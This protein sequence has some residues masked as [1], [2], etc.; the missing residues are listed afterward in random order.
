MRRVS[1]SMTFFYKRIFPVLWFGI[2]GV[3]FIVALKDPI[4][5]LPFALGVLALMAFGYFFMRRFIFD[6][7]DEVLDD[8]DALILRNGGRRE[9]VALSDIDSVSYSTA[10][11]PPRVTL[12]LRR[13]TVFGE[14]VAFCAPLMSVPF[15]KSEVV[16]NLIARIEQARR[17]A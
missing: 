13:P 15:I 6:M 9:R 3:S 17:T 16:T 4:A 1:S 2:L 5:V 12:S 10:V 8:G 14:K 7:L 11:N